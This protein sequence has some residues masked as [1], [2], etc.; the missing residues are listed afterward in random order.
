MGFWS[1]IYHGLVD[2]GKDIHDKYSDPFTFDGAMAIL[3]GGGAP[4]IEFSIEG[5]KDNWSWDS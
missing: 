3:T 1:D 5:T 4:A 2:V